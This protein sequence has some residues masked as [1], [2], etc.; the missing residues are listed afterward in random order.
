MYFFFSLY[1]YFQVREACRHLATNFPEEIVEEAIT[2]LDK[3]G[4][5][6]IN[7]DDIK[8]LVRETT[9]MDAKSVAS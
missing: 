3:D 6:K 5:G 7:R 9:H 8:R 4:D 2:R 1:F